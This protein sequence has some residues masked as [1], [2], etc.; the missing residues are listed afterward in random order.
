MGLQCHVSFLNEGKHRRK[1]I[2][3]GITAEAIEDSNVKKKTCLRL[4][5]GV[6][7]SVGGGHFVGWCVSVVVLC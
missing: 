6:R 4:R 5:F 2:N 1:D 3:N 7:V